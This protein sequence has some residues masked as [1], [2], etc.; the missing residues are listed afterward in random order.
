M[1]HGSAFSSWRA[2]CLMSRFVCLSRASSEYVYA[3]VS[4]GMRSTM[5]GAESGG[6]MNEG[7]R[8]SV[9]NG[10]GASIVWN[11]M[12]ARSGRRVRAEYHGRLACA[13]TPN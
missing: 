11:A 13:T 5:A 9:R 10:S 1:H 6:V 8:D 3:A 7:V 12:A 2:F 4:Y